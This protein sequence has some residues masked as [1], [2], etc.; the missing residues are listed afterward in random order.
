MAA[1]AA[2]Q[3]LVVLNNIKG[4]IGQQKEF[5]M[6]TR[7]SKKGDRPGVCDRIRPIETPCTSTALT[8]EIPDGTD[9]FRARP[10]LENT[11]L[12]PGQTIG[13]GE[14]E[15]RGR[16][17]LTATCCRTPRIDGSR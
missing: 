15:R 3:D 13:R 2:H 16:M 12:A 9:Q 11:V 6:V 17:D 14:D 8:N 10:A 5:P 7:G 4:C 1:T